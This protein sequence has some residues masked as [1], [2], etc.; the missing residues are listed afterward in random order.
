MIINKKNLSQFIPL[1]VLLGA[2]LIT[3]A[4][5]QVKPEIKEEPEETIDV[6]V[7]VIYAGHGE[8]EW[9]L[10]F[11]AEVRAQNT[12]NLVSEVSGKIVK[13]ADNFVEGGA[14]NTAETLIWVD[15]TEYQLNLASSRADLAQ[16]ETELALALGEAEIKA[17][18]WK[19]VNPNKKAKPLQLNKP[20]VEQAQAQLKAAKA[21]WDKARLNVERTKITVPFSGRVQSKTVG[22]GQFIMP[23]AIVGHVFSTDKVEI[24]LSLTEKQLIELGL[25]PGYQSTENNYIMANIVHSFGGV[26]NQWQGYIKSVDANIESSTRLIFATIVVDDPYNT[27]KPYPL[28][29]GSFV[30]VSLDAIKPISGIKIP[31]DALRGA[32]KVYVVKENKLQ[33]KTLDVLSSSEDVA[34][35]GGDIA[36]GDAVVISPLA[37]AYEGMP[38]IVNNQRE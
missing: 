21:Q 16:A 12:I 10:E 9:S 22:L 36:E 38:T 8:F 25:K 32:D 35:V 15:D 20:Q 4:L 17:A 33:I 26:L 27:S 19:S 23:G 13:I 3:W 28:S 18:Q 31:R 6:T 11:Q 30:A 14:F 1:L 29:P 34:I 2:V 37:G 5:I 7:D 24:R